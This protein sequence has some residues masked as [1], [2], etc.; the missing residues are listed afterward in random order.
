M[1]SFVKKQFF[2][3]MNLVIALIMIAMKKIF[4]QILKNGIIMVTIS[5]SLITNWDKNET[6]GFSAIQPTINGESL[7]LLS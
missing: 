6:I 7:S 3:E 4:Q 2:Q 1:E 5:A